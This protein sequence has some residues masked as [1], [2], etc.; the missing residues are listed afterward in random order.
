MVASNM[1]NSK[2]E[3]AIEKE[4]AKV[5]AAVAPKEKTSSA[6][7]QPGTPEWAAWA[8]ENRNG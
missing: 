5:E 4:A 6:T 3:A 7:P 2:V 8:W 1:E